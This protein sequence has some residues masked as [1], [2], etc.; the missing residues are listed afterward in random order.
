MPEKPAKDNINELKTALGQYSLQKKIAQGGMAEIFKGVSL[1][2]HGIKRTVV[3]K[4]ILPHIAA[5]RE[6]V[7]MLVSEAKIA[8]QLSHGN[9]AQIYDLGRTGNDYFMVMEYV[10]GKSLSHI[11]KRCLKEGHLI[12]LPYLLY[13]ISEVADGLDYMHGKKDAAGVPLGIVH[14]DISP[15]NIIV[16][17]SG[18]V[19]I[20]DFGI[21][22]AATKIDKTEAGVLKGKFAYMSPEQARGENIDHRSDIFSL[23]V[24]FH[25]MSCGRRLFKDKDNKATIR[26]VRRA[27]FSA[28]ST[29]NVELP[30]EIDAIVMKALSKDPADRYQSAGEFRDNVVR[31]LHTRYPEFKTAS[32]VKFIEDLFGEPDLELE[33]E[34]EDMTPLLIIDQTQ[35]AIQ[36]GAPSVLQ[37]FMLG[38][39]AQ[40]KA[41]PAGEERQ[42]E[43]VLEGGE[44]ALER[45]M[46]VGLLEKLGNRL[47]TI[48]PVLRP[49]GWS[50]AVLL[51]VG[52]VLYV[53]HRSGFWQKW[54]DFFRA[55]TI[56]PA[57]GKTEQLIK[58][59]KL[60]TSSQPSGARVYIDDVETGFKTPA[61]IEA[62]KADG[63]THKIGFFL[64]GYNYN[65]STFRAADENEIRF[66][67][68]LTPAYGGIH[69]ISSPSDANVYLN[70][71]LA[72]T[73][74]FEDNEISPGSI[75]I[76]RVEKEGYSSLEKEA[77]ISPSKT[78][79][80]RAS[81]MKERKKTV[82]PVV[83][84]PLQTE[85]KTEKEKKKEQAEPF[86][87]G[88]RIIREKFKVEEAPAEEMPAE[89]IQHQEE[90]Q[91]E[92]EV[93]KDEEIGNIQ[94]TE[95][96]N[97]FSEM[98][99]PAGLKKKEPEK[100][101]NP[102]PNAPEPESRKKPLRLDYN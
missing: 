89:K 48:I 53:G 93:R 90:E 72:G 19:K 29:Y 54:S 85:Q 34:E 41:G 66:D 10:D 27:E 80:L 23:G 95:Q 43:P 38:E 69:V 102:A 71:K 67:P 17:Y 4:K 62:F 56:G 84:P 22:K 64:Q 16:S 99:P 60:V 87:S 32:I 94:I 2:I 15:Q 58:H 101:E 13:F 88:E 1:D 11:H 26:N 91:K 86:L 31:F 74:P 21:A 46:T 73:T 61:T 97:E 30:K 63:E 40:E 8:V 75:F 49:V 12:P 65:E 7:D 45:K 6:F 37:E 83:P 51:V 79:V 33:K 14:R 82:A 9:I 42:N 3:I 18:T 76:V 28:P 44:E 96:D 25:E 100:G 39:E 5:N 20:I 59:T 55:E 77:K 70:D 92:S 98:L 78:L 47:K 57:R 36:T 24:I 81:L 68:I 35:S 50:L 52:C